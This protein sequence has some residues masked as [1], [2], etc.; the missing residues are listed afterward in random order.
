MDEINTSLLRITNKCNQNCIFC[1]VYG[2]KEE[3]FKLNNKEIYLELLRLKNIGVEGIILTGG[4]P[5]LVRNINR[6]IILIKNIGFKKIYMQ[7]NGM[8]FSNTE[9]LKNFLFEHIDTFLIPLYSHNYKISDAVTKTPNSFNQTVKGIK[10][11]ISNNKKIIINHMIS[12]FNY[13]D[14]NKFSDF[15]NNEFSNK[16]TISISYIQPNGRSYN[17]K[18][19]VPKMSK[20]TILMVNFMEQLKENNINFFLSEGCP[21]VCF[22]ENYKEY[23]IEYYKLKNKIFDNSYIPNIKNKQKSKKCKL[24]IYT[25]FCLGVWKNYKDLYGFDEINPVLK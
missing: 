2:K 4:E 21:P 13:D 7:T 23:H 12:K 25:D 16:V 3:N 9:Y 20:I 19:L 8:I 14:L 11:L 15:I 1:N 6:I 17:K 18:E 22:Y 24:C 5:T 10:N